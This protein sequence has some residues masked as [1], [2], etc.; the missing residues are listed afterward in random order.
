MFKDRA[1]LYLAL[2]ETLVWAVLYYVFPALLLRWEQDTDWS[3]SE[4][5]AAITFAVLL[6]AAISPLTGRL[7][8]AGR[9][10]HL[11]AGSAV[12]GG[13]GLLALSQVTSL[14][15]FYGAWAVVGLSLAGCLYEPCFALVTRIRGSAARHG[16]I[17]I[18]LVAGF[19]SAI[20]FPVTHSLSELFG[21]RITVTVFGAVAIVIVAPI[22]W[23]GAS[24]LENSKP[25]VEAPA[26]PATQSRN[27]F[28]KTTTFWFLA[29]G[30]ACAA[31]LHGATLQH[32]LPLLDERGVAADMAVL[33]A[34]F[35]GPM[36][37]AGRLA[38]MASEKHTSNHG[39]A[40]CA[41]FLMCLSVLLLIID[42]SS[43][44]SLVAFVTL[45]GG[46]YG[47]V[48]IIRPLIAREIL[49]EADFGAKSGALALPYLAGSASA[50][51]FG[52]LLWD[53]GGYNLM[54]WVITGLG[55]L[56]LLL[57]LAARKRALV[58]QEP[59]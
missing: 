45:F 34:S 55:L 37:V 49:G 16:I 26:R 4:L 6:S 2:G 41:F 13:L 17:L 36:Q 59:S 52:S 53:V 44:L 29:I 14:W 28:L 50:P 3:K 46:A 19:A 31:V 42:G 54:L 15:A 38:M 25:V 11:M 8:D 47:T 51:Y 58:K 20:S 9:G 23:R 32:L 43:P 39:V 27:D 24:L 10:P 21:W 48:S 33:V 7:I 5:T 30:F 12:L 35:V 40:I 56:G 22:L 1:I 18:T 57:Y